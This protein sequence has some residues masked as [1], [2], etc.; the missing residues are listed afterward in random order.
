MADVDRTNF[1]ITINFRNGEDI[2]TGVDEV[3]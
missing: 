1:V 3:V 2:S